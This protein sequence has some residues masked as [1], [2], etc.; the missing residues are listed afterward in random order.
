M[1]EN[2]HIYRKAKG[3][4]VTRL[5]YQCSISVASITNV[6]FTSIWAC[7][8]VHRSCFSF[9]YEQFVI[10]VHR[11]SPVSFMLI[12]G[13]RVR[14]TFTHYYYFLHPF[15]FSHHHNKYIHFFILLL[16]FKST[17]F[18]GNPISPVLLPN[19]TTIFPLQQ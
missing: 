1:C 17:G 13:L 11:P 16:I 19:L 14:P 8:T 2:I 15:Y 12:S 10:C 7:L 6:Y 4:I 5:C 3:R 9:Q 18:C